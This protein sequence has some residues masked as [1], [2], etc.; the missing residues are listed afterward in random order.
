MQT[1]ERSL[2]A[3]GT[4]LEV[5]LLIEYF[6]EQRFDGGAYTRAPLRTRRL[7]ADAR[8]VA[9]DAVEVLEQLR[10]LGVPRQTFE[11]RLALA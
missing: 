6:F 8:E 1:R 7:A 9:V 10:R 4:K 5:A 11:R 3:L 2:D